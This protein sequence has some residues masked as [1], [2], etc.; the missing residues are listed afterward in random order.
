MEVDDPWPSVLSSG[1]S[2]GGDVGEAAVGEGV[3][4]D[5]AVPCNHCHPEVDLVFDILRAV[6]VQLFGK[7]SL[8]NAA[9]GKPQYF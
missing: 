3:D 8:L 2:L 9:P 1:Q 4:S 5:R 7:R 6:L